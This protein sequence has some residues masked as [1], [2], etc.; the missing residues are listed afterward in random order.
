VFRWQPARN[1]SVPIIRRD[2]CAFLERNAAQAQGRSLNERGNIMK[3]LLFAVASIGLLGM[4]LAPS[5]RA[6]EWNKKTTLTVNETISVP[7]RT[8]APGEYVV[9]LL[10]SPS[11]RHIVQVF[12][13]DE[14]QVLTTILA[15]PN[16]RLRPTGKTVF[17]FWEMPPGQPKALRAWFYP[18]DNFGQE[19]A[20]PKV[21][22]T[23][24]AAVAH[25]AVP[26][27]EAQKP[28]E[29]AAA[30]I[31]KVEPPA[32]AVPAPVEIAQAPPA[33][34]VVAPPVELPKTAGPYPLIGFAG[35]LSLLVAALLRTVRTS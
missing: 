19:F 17:S 23:E 12:N 16:Y 26:T 30:P 7:G 25:V 24:I 27:T 33:P 9:K 14:T 31:A 34:Q 3:R 4:A 10:D 5:A 35:I 32:P 15:I 13:A 2:T 29:M 18:G 28:A 22:A 6:D 8:L 1:P 20:Y 21:E 11:D